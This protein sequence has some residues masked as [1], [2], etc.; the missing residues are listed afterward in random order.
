MSKRKC[1]KAHQKTLNCFKNQYKLLLN[2]LVNIQ[3]KPKYEKGLKILTSKQII[4]R[5][6][7]TFAQ[8]KAGNTSENVLNEIKE[9]IYYLQRAKYKII[10][11]YK[12]I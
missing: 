12:S 3:H 11:H 5:L 6:L 7:T 10:E 8:V 9:T 2:Y 4:Q 1:S